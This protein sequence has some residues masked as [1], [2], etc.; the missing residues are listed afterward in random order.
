MWFHR[1][2]AGLHPQACVGGVVTCPNCELARS[3]FPPTP[4]NE[5]L[6]V[7]LMRLKAHALQP[8]SLAT[9]WSGVRRFERFLRDTGNTCDL[10]TGKRPA[11]S[12]YPETIMFF[13][14]WARKR[15]APATTL[16]TLAAIRRWHCENDLR[17]PTENRALLD[18]MTL[19]KKAARARSAKT[20]KLP[21]PHSLIPVILRW[22]DV[23]SRDHGRWSRELIRG[24]ALLILG[25]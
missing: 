24:G 25:F 11:A 4:G 2:C 19:L 20:N 14:A 1:E 21:Y 9:Y 22:I 7:E 16:S 3:R 12:F 6:A 13:I 17:Y 5:A 10:F 15:Y 23:K 18:L 8:A